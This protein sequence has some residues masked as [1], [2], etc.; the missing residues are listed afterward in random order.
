MNVPHARIKTVIGIKGPVTRD[1]DRRT[2]RKVGR[3]RY[4]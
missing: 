1:I 2:D 4:G 3:M